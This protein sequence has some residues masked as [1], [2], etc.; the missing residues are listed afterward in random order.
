MD[1]GVFT[2]IVLRD[3][4]MRIV[5]DGERRAHEALEAASKAKTEFL[6]RMSHELRTP[7]N[8][9]IGFSKLLRLDTAEPLSV[10]Q[11]ERVQHV[12]N[13]GSHLLALVNDVLDLSRIESGEMSVSSQAVQLP[14]VIEEA[15]T[16]VSPLV[17]KAGIEVFVASE[18]P[19]PGQP[20]R[21]DARPLS[22]GDVWVN[23]DPV[24]LRQVLVNLLSNAVKYNRPGGRVALTWRRTDDACEILVT[25]TGQGIPA[26][27]LACLFQP[28]N[29]LGAEST[30]VEGTGI[31][32]V[33]SRQ[34]AEMMGGSL[35]ISSTFGVGTCASLR[36]GLAQAP[37]VKAVPARLG[38]AEERAAP[39]LTVLYAEDD[40]VN[41]ELVR[42]LVTM[43]RGVSLRVATSG[44]MALECA[45]ADPPD[46]ML[47]DMNL[48]D[49]TG[50]EL[51]S[52]LQESP[53]TA[54]LRLVALSADALPEQIS[55]TLAAGFETYLTKPVDFRKFLDVLD[56][57]LN[58]EV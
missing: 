33:L 6:S 53:Q 18:N 17:T 36:L 43:R 52:A 29:R 13:A 46:L 35:T 55:A 7:L 19:V 41:A 1:T 51:A 42:Q 15:A 27:Q 47:V 50:I 23:A 26:E 25:D 5:A 24:R 56:S 57:H 4:T 39:A 37:A 8:A 22:P 2:T 16:M 49:M 30:T 32:L 12:E 45:R 10:E 40:E 14:R 58:A 54:D 28:F 9:V 3:I 21:A 48:G 44:A 11:L 20:R 38:R 34:L 31:G